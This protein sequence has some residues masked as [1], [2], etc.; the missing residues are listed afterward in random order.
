M[1]TS[2]SNNRQKSYHSLPLL[3]DQFQ[4]NSEPTKS[5]SNNNEHYSID[6]QKSKLL[7]TVTFNEFKTYDTNL[8]F[9][10]TKDMLH[11]SAILRNG[12]SANVENIIEEGFDN[13]IKMQEEQQN[14]KYVPYKTVNKSFLNEESKHTDLS[15]LSKIGLNDQTD[16]LQYDDNRID[17]FMSAQGFG[18]QNSENDQDHVYLKYPREKLIEAKNG[19]DMKFDK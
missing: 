3:I 6:E 8:P 9:F 4:N 7:T 15:V 14:N 12:Q 10:N 17:S 11:S 19:R 1:G 5:M 16:E 2:N 13:S 18:E